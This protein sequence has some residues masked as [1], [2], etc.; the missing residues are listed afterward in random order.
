[1]KYYYEPPEKWIVEHAAIYIC[2]H[3]LYDKCTLFKKGDYGLALIQ[4]KFNHK[5]KQ[6]WWGPI[7][8]WLIEDLYSQPGWLD[9]FYQHCGGCKDGLYP[10]V[11]VRKAM[12]AMRMKPLKRQ[13]WEEL[14][15]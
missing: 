3:P 8:P 13:Y 5:T 6:S 9:W 12:W 14:A 15:K 1:M 7:D 2:N 4:Q 11:T 10:T